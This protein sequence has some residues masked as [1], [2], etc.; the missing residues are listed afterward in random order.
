MGDKAACILRC[1]Q[2]VLIVV[3]VIFIILGIMGFVGLKYA[4]GGG[5][6]AFMVIGAI[7]FIVAGVFAFIT[8][9]KGR[10]SRPLVICFMITMLVFFVVAMIQ[11]II[12]AM[13]RADC[14]NTGAPLNAVACGAGWQYFFALAVILLFT[15]IIGAA[16]AFTFWRLLRQEDE[17]G[18]KY[19]YL[20]EAAY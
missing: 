17:G 5:N 20:A 18:D 3:G 9:A 6:I 8:S 16:A 1:W 10:Q 12:G 14:N 19:V 4:Q 11:L 7:V 2:I 13:A 15:S